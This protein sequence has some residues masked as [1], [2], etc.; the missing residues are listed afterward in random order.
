[1][2]VVKGL[3]TVLRFLSMLRQL[4]GVFLVAATLEPL[5]VMAVAAWRIFWWGCEK[6]FSESLGWVC[7]ALGS[8]VDRRLGAQHGKCRRRPPRSPATHPDWP[9]TG[10]PP[11]IFV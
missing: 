1:M 5:T 6:L 10:T 4:S 2:E 11:T 7:V 8:G 9:S 3:R